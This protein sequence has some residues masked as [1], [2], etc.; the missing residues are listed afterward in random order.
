MLFFGSIFH[1]WLSFIL[2]FSIIRF[3]IIYYYL[4]LIYL[5]FIEFIISFNI[6]HYK[7]SFVKIKV[8]LFIEIIII[9][10]IIINNS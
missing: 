9:I 3:T 8:I 6:R 4:S 5:L 10:I 2:F 1:G 7:T